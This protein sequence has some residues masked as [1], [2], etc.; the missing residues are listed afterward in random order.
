MVEALVLMKIIGGT[1]E[2]LDWAKA[3]RRRYQRFLALSKFSGSW[4]ATTWWLE[5]KPRI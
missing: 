5:S 1:G 4:G 3:Q 2:S